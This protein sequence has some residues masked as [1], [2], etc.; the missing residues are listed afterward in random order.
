MRYG[1]SMSRLG[2]L[3]AGLLVCMSEAMACGSGKLILE[4]KFESLDPA[5]GFSDKDDTRKN[6]PG[7]PTR[8]SPATTS[9][10]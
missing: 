7:L 3:A 1:L 4:E 6:G 5:W 10:S 2:V 9:F 8:S